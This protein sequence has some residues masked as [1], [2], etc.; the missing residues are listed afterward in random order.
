MFRNRV[1]SEFVLTQKVSLVKERKSAEKRK[2]AN[3]EFRYIL[4]PM[5]EQNT[6]QLDFST[7]FAN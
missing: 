7:N 1:A 2:T 3:K 4:D 5:R 6:S